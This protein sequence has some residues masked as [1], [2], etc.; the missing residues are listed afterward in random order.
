M[1]WSFGIAEKVWKTENWGWF[2]NDG[3][4]NWS[5]RFVCEE[6]LYRER[7]TYLTASHTPASFQS[8]NVIISV[9]ERCGRSLPLF[10][11][12]QNWRLS[13][14]GIPDIG[15]HMWRQSSRSRSKGELIYKSCWR[16]RWTAASRRFHDEQT[17]AKI[18]CRVAF[19]PHP[20][21]YKGKVASPVACALGQLNTHKRFIGGQICTYYLLWLSMGHSTHQKCTSNTMSLWRFGCSV[22]HKVV[23]H[24][25]SGK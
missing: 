1:N 24:V 6:N 15:T 18:D 19:R 5:V 7:L 9:K 4:I 16:V 2:W 8:R 25:W 22:Q 12:N 13:R 3:K 20:Q 21:S 23:E 10:W 11:I 17:P 14:E